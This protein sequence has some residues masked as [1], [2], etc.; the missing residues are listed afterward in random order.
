MSNVQKLLILW[1]SLVGISPIQ[2]Q[3]DLS[4]IPNL[5]LQNA[6]PAAFVRMESPSKN[7]SSPDYF[8]IVKASS[9][10]HI[11]HFID[12]PITVNIG[13]YN[14]SNYLNA[15]KDAFK[16][17]EIDSH[18]I[19]NFKF[20]TDPQNA[21]IK[22][23]WNHLGLISNNG[24]CALGAHTITRYNLTDT[25]CQS[26]YINNNIPGATTQNQRKYSVPP[27][28]IEVNLDLI[29][30]KPENIRLLVLK[31]ILT[32]EIGHALGL[33]GHSTSLSDMMY[34]ITDEYSHISKRDIQTLEL[35]YNTPCDIAL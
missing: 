6:Y 34:S 2:A 21:R 8:D 20:V 35:L 25:G 31:N 19:V 3:N 12:F 29:A 22:I 23:I 11:L 16:T 28:I 18:G 33:L 1:L 15:C 26:F 30:S 17:W 13:T 32:H 4:L 24:N 7:N 5:P 9:Q 14:D 10:S 27:Q